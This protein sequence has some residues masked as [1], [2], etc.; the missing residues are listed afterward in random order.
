MDR[1][2]GY[3]MPGLAGSPLTMYE[4]MTDH[5]LSYEVRK[6]RDELKEAKLECQA[7]EQDGSPMLA[8]AI[9]CRVMRLRHWHHMARSQWEDRRAALEAQRDG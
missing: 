5:E 6:L 8:A 3:V 2:E 9:G 4:A 7:A 1:R